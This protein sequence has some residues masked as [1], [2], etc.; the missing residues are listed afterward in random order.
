MHVLLLELYFHVIC[1]KKQIIVGMR[2][3]AGPINVGHNLKNPLSG[4]TLLVLVVQ[5]NRY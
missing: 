2:E 1:D 5:F 4:D 3:G